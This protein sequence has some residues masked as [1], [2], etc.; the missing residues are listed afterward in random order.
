MNTHQQRPCKLIYCEC[1]KYFATAKENGME[2]YWVIKEIELLKHVTAWLSRKLS[3]VKKTNKKRRANPQRFH[4]IWFHYIDLSDKT[5]KMNTSMTAEGYR[6]GMGWNG[7]Y[8]TYIW[9]NIFTQY[10]FHVMKR[11]EIY[12]K[13]FLKIFNKPPWRK[14]VWETRKRERKRGRRGKN[15]N[16]LEMILMTS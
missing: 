11:M 14:Y 9:W 1:L 3:Q 8:T 10:I 5:I 6:Q 16:I 7:R 4:T 15:E 2:C 13:H 12:L